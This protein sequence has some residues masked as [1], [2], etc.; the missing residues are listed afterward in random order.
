MGPDTTNTGFI[1]RMRR[2]Q[3][4]VTIG[5]QVKYVWNSYGTRFI[6]KLYSDLY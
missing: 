3:T 6:G 2:F 1:Q 5:N 4:Q